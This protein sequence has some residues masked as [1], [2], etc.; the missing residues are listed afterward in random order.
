LKLRFWYKIPLTPEEKHIRN[1]QRWLGLLSGVLLGL[2]FPPIPFP[3]TLLIFFGLIPY[4]FVLDKKEK[5]V[6][7]N[8]FTYLTAFVFNVITIYWV[9][10]WQ[11]EADP[12]LMIAGGVLLFFNPILFLIPSTL[13]YLTKQ[14][15]NKK[16]AFY[17]FPFFWVTYEYLYMI[18][19]ASFPWL[20]ISNGLPHFLTFIQIADIIGA[21]G[22][23]LIVVYINLF[24][25][26]VIMQCYLK[27][28]KLNYSLKS[29]VF[30]LTLALVLFLTSII[31]GIITKSNY[32]LPENKIKVGLIQPNL[33]PWDKWN[34]GGLW[35]M[36]NIYFDLSRQ[37]VEKKADVIFWPE[38]AFPIYL[39]DGSHQEL[40]DSIYIFINHNQ[41][42]LITG[43]PDFKFF[44]NKDIAPSDAKY[45]KVNNYYYTIYNGILF[46]SPNT[47]E[48]EH[49]GKMKLVPFGERVPFV[50]ALPWIGDL[51]KWQVGI[52]GW[53]KGKD[54]VVFALLPQKNIHSSRKDTVRINSLVCF[55]SVYPTFV[56]QFV[57]KGAQLI[58]VVT[59]DSWYGNSSGP[60]QH[61]EIAV[62]RAV[63]NRRTVVRAANGG[64]STI[65]DPLGRTVAETKMYTKT[66]IAGDAPLETRM[67]F[68]SKNPFI[69]P[70]IS[71]MISLFVVG[72][73]F[74][75]KLK[76]L[77]KL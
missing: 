30:A 67:T 18:T 4:F 47:K 6:D 19:D 77:L 48:I 5:L 61:K 65:I 45:N 9:G 60:Y 1:I 3:A 28:Q 58:S 38:T 42:Y 22:L 23:S 75:G 59:N 10:S 34:A 51:I 49:Y 40:L 29:L 63:E 35:N 8:R 17:L 74:I 24:L 55:E 54:T 31:Y 14:L 66:F 46:F 32:K 43:M 50:D 13:F 68:F 64:I 73:F 7:I 25:F 12:F 57:Q 27:R 70:I 26:I 11:S 41:V 15:F 53:N 72:I 71:S 16:T 62:L 37:A 20:S 69:V 39:L 36:A 52:S 21:L 33:N 44:G 76:S 56:A 2:S